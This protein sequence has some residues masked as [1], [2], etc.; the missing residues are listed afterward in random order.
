MRALAHV[1]V[2]AAFLVAGARLA[3][4]QEPVLLV[5]PAYTIFETPSAV[6]YA[7][8]VTNKSISSLMTKAVMPSL[9]HEDSR[10]YR[11][12]EGSVFWLNCVPRLAFSRCM[13]RRVTP[14]SRGRMASMDA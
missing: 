6:E 8:T 4:A 5:V 11:R 1:L 10:F 2:A 14:S 3:C 9:T 13:M 12:G 7:R